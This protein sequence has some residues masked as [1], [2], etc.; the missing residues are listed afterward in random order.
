MCVQPVSETNTKR[1]CSRETQSDVVKRAVIQIFY[2]IVWMGE[3][4]ASSC[5]KGSGHHVCD[6]AVKGSVMSGNGGP[7]PALPPLP[8]DPLICFSRRWMERVRW[9]EELTLDLEGEVMMSKQ[10]QLLVLYY[11]QT[12]VLLTS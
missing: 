10:S 7:F 9:E 3:N 8:Y 6:L 4:L 11:S 1:L 2:I 5:V 12:S